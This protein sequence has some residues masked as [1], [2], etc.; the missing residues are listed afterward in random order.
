MVKD[1]G[2]DKKNLTKTKE[3]LEESLRARRQELKIRKE[4]NLPID[5][6]HRDRIDI[7]EKAL[8]LARSRLNEL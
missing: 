2:Y 1:I 7:E 4:N 5:K 8:S 3:I 6:G